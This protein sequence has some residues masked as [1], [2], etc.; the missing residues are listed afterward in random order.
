METNSS[1]RLF[2]TVVEWNNGTSE[3]TVKPPTKYYNWRTKLV[4][5][6]RD[7]TGSR[8]LADNIGDNNV[9]IIQESV[10]MSSSQSLARGVRDMIKQFADDE[11]I[12]VNVFSGEITIDQA[13]LNEQDLEAF[14]RLMN[15]FG[16]RGRPPVK[17]NFI[18]TDLETL[19]TYMVEESEVAVTPN[20]SLHFNAIE[21][22]E[23]PSFQGP[24][25]SLDCLLNARYTSGK[26]IANK[27]VDGYPTPPA[28]P[29]LDK[30]LEDEIAAVKNGVKAGKLPAIYD[31]N[32]VDGTSQTVS[33]I[34]AV[35]VGR[36][37]HDR[38]FLQ[39]RRIE[40]ITAFLVLGGDISKATSMDVR[41]DEADWF[42]AAAIIAPEVVARNVYYKIW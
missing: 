8:S 29:P 23:I 38:A 9:L 19:Q 41:P 1:K 35:I 34:D 24:V 18:L 37:Y 27:W 31:P 3:E 26:W 28:H 36:S 4:G 6:L 33:C 15:V 39:K 11:Q 13:D 10:I 40:A 30:N 20:G 42:D 32:N 21:G 22:S 14:C 5:K 7:A 16:R 12:S 2:C 25:T 17:Q